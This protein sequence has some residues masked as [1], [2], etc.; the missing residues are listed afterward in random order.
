MGCSGSNENK[1]ERDRH[2][3]MPH[4]LPRR[5]QPR[6]HP[7]LESIR[8]R[9]QRE[10]VR[11]Q[12]VDQHESSDGIKGEKSR[13]E[14]SFLDKM[15]HEVSVLYCTFWKHRNSD[16]APESRIYYDPLLQKWILWNA[17]DDQ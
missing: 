2:R 11:Q 7:T 13:P 15:T 9:F 12:Y 5:R 6:R 16:Q 1:V 14:D 4:I 10:H 3:W 17:E 8:S